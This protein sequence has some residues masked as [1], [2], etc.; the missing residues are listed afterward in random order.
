MHVLLVRLSPGGFR[1]LKELCTVSSADIQLRNA[2]QI[3]HVLLLQWV[4]SA[5]TKEVVLLQ[6]N[7]GGC[8]EAAGQPGKAPGTHFRHT[9]DRYEKLPAPKFLLA[10]WMMT[11]EQRSHT[12]WFKHAAR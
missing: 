1:A 3:L 7:L 11:H 5:G 9:S 12:E 6:E 10:G 2:E 4:F 8:D